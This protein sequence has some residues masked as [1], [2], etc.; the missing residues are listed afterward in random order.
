[1]LVAASISEPVS[2][3]SGWRTVA[4]SSATAACAVAVAAAGVSSA[5]AITRSFPSFHGRHVSL[6][7]VLP[8]LTERHLHH[9][10]DKLVRQGHSA[11]TSRSAL[12]GT[13]TNT[14]A[15]PS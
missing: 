8:F 15:Q 4:L 11:T 9:Y 6:I 1:M 3:S 10:A 7:H 13:L 5:V 2:G 14:D 12:G